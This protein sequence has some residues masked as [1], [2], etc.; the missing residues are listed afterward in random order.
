[1]TELNGAVVRWVSCWTG[2][3]RAEE[4][5]KGGATYFKLETVFLLR[6]PR[7]L[8]TTTMGCGQSSHFSDAG[9]GQLLGSAT[10]STTSHPPPTSKSNSNSAT[11]RSG[12]IGSG[13]AVGG[14]QSKGEAERREAMAK[15]AEERNKSVSR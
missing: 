14:G 12:I 4:E 3:K 10:S 11:A 5:A 2:T 1:M 13:R 8:L 9:P 6:H 7:P 15:A